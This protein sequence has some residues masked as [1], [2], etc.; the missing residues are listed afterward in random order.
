MPFAP[1]WLTGDAHLRGKAPELNALIDKY[2]PCT[3]KPEPE[4]RYFEI[5]VRGI[6]SQQLPPEVVNEIYLRL[7]SHLGSITPGQLLT[8]DCEALSKLGLVDQKIQ[9]LKGFSQMV[10]DKKVTLDKF[11]DMTDGEITKQLL[12]VKG[13]GQ[14]TIEMFLLLAL[15][16]T[17]ISPTADHVFKKA[18]K[19]LLQL[20]EIP[21]RGQINRITENWR[22]WRSL[23]VWYLWRY[24]DEL[25]PN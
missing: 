18:L 21:K 15:C 19:T 24:A 16:R 17:D 2:G 7:K 25:W 3:L 1:D 5:L 20:P 23:A 9:Y 4:E 11:A 13:L 14:W 6:I 10:L 8:S 22:P 12:G